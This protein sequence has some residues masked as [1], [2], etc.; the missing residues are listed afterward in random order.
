M[1]GLCEDEVA[2]VASPDFEADLLFE[3]LDAMA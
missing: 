3:F 2:T 1:A